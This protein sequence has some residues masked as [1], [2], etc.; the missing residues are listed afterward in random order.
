MQEEKNVDEPPPLVKTISKI[1]GQF[2]NPS[3]YF[4]V[5][6]SLLLYEVWSKISDSYN[7]ILNKNP[8]LEK[9]I[10]EKSLR[11]YG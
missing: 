1:K 3:E 6:E 9:R 7:I 8:S 4:S 2:E 10:F 5:V 11:K